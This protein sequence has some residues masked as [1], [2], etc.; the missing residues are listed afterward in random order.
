MALGDDG[1]VGSIFGAASHGAPAGQLGAIDV[2]TDSWAFGPRLTYPLI[3]TR[4]E[5]LT[6]DGGFTV[7]DAHVNILGQKISHDQWRVADLAVTYLRNDFLEGNW[8][9]TIDASQ[10]L[11]VFGATPNHSPALSL[12]GDPDFTK[13]TGLVRYTAPLF[14]A[15][16]FA[17]TA[18]GQYSFNPLIE[19][20]QI[21]FGGSNI[22]R[23]YEPGAI[24]G[25]SGLGGSAELRYDTHLPDYFIQDLQP[26]IYLDG[27]RTWNIKRPEEVGLFRQS[28]ASTGAGLR[29]YFPYNLYADLEVAR[30]LSPVPGSDHDKR[31]TK[32]LTDI[33]I[34][35]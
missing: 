24:T 34:T 31:E 18:Q 12:G 16:S 8:A 9:A 5:T 17:G 25:D 11:P 15:F 32:L 30:T 3:R 21:L 7:Q 13:L 27:A 35:F 29:L 28:I 19:G 2:R 20:E 26:Y 1:L 22:G 10:G 14:D 4:D 23:G 6:L 33:A